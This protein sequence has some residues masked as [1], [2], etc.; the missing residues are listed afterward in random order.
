MNEKEK[1][2]QFTRE[3]VERFA[4]FMLDEMIANDHK[5][6][7]STWTD[8]TSIMMEFHYHEAKLILAL[9]QGNSDLIKEHA[10]DVANFMMM[11]LNATGNLH[12]SEP[13][14]D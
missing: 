4:S 5:G 2:H 6:D 7:W 12:P 3:A 10:A 1:S 9:S 8:L 13:K 14:V 11:L